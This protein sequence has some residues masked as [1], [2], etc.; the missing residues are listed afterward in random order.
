MEREFFP[1]SLLSP[2]LIPLSNEFLRFVESATTN[3]TQEDLNEKYSKNLSLL[4]T[5][6][7]DRIQKVLPDIS[8]LM[9]FLKSPS[10]IT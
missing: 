2:S 10:V 5:K 1:N 3:V 4:K 6:L 8:H 9:N 7:H